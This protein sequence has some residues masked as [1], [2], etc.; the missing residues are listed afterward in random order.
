MKRLFVLFLCACGSDQFVGDGGADSGTDGIP[1]SEGGGSDG[2]IESGG[3]ATMPPKARLFASV[4][5]INGASTLVGWDDPDALSVPRQPDVAVDVPAATDIAVAKRARVFVSGDT[6]IFV[7]EKPLELTSMSTYKSFDKN[8]FLG[9]SQSDSIAVGALWYDPMTDILVTGDSGKSGAQ[10]FKPAA[11]MPIPTTSSARVLANDP[12]RYP[13]VANGELYLSTSGAS[14]YFLQGVGAASG[15]NITT[16]NFMIGTGHMAVANGRLYIGTFDGGSGGAE[17]LIYQHPVVTSM[18]SWIAQVK[19]V[20]G[21]APMSYTVEDV[22]VS[23]NWMAAGVWK[24]NSG[25]DCYICVFSNPNTVDGNSTC[26]NKIALGMGESLI[27][28]FERN[29]SLYVSVG[30]MPSRIDIYRNPLTDTKPV[31]K[32]DVG[33]Q[34]FVSGFA[35][36]E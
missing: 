2:T 16:S 9:L 34:R 21:G 7:F 12:I 32:L 3:D 5:N 30:G 14:S 17:V 26:A 23:T 33:M 20:F 6:A 10:I 24:N 29:G 1:V 22:A 11:T 27:R 31:V 25:S 15:A 8:A 13:I 36:A 18:P 4:L 35:A 19:T 28:M